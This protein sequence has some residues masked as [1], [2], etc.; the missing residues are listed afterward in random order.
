MD[1]VFV[2]VLL[3]VTIVYNVMD[4]VLIVV[5]VTAVFSLN[6]HL[7]VFVSLV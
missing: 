6:N 4:N 5:P 3:N 2:F 7:I 1:V